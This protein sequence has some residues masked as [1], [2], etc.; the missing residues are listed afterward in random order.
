MA[1]IHVAYSV[2]QPLLPIR[3]AVIALNKRELAVKK[4]IVFVLSLAVL[5][6]TSLLSGCGGGS[7]AVVPPPPPPPPALAITTTSLATGNVG[8]LYSAGIDSNSTTPN[9]GQIWSVSSG[10]PSGLTFPPP[11]V[12]C[13]AGC[14]I[15]GT[16]TAQGTFSFTITI[17]DVNG[18]T[19]SRMFSI[20]IGPPL[21][22]SVTTPSP[23]PEGSVN[24][25]YAVA[26]QAA[27]G[28]PPFAWRLASG[29]PLPNNLALD[30]SGNISSGTLTLTTFGNF[31]FTATVTDS[32]T[33]AQ[34]A[35]ATFSLT[36]HTV[37]FG[38]YVF[39]F[40]GFDANGAV[41][42]AGSFTAD[43][44]GGITGGVEDANR[45]VSGPA[46]NVPFTGSYAMGLDNRGTL[47][48]TSSLGTSSFAFI[49]DGGQARFI[50]LDTSGTRG[51]GEMQ[52]TNGGC[53]L[54]NVAETIPYVFGM[55]GD[56]FN[57]G[58][59]ALAGSFQ[60]DGAG[61]ITA[62]ALDEND[63]GTLASNVTWTGTNATSVTSNRCTMTLT[64]AGSPTRNFASYGGNG[65]PSYL[66]E[67]DAVSS[68]V[69][70]MAGTAVAVSP[71]G[72]APAGA[73]FTNASLK[74]PIVGSLTG[75]SRVTNAPDVSLVFFSPDGNGN[76][77]MTQDENNG[78]AV[79]TDVVLTGTYNVG[80]N[81]RVTLTA[82][83]NPPVLYLANPTKAFI[84]GTDK[85][86]TFGFLEP[87]ISYGPLGTFSASIN[88]N[89]HFGTDNPASATIN[90]LSGVTPFDAT[91]TLSGTWDESTLT[92]NT[93]GQTFTGTYSVTNM[94]VNGSGTLTITP[95]A[96]QPANFVFMTLG[97][98]A[99]THSHFNGRYTVCDTWAP[100][101]ATKLIAIP[102]DATQ[103]NPAVLVLEQ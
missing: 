11:G 6:V 25:A 73:L 69:P 3:T 19:A 50:E 97:A 36:I 40:H 17:R 87:Q 51:S 81:G 28:V 74:N 83:A 77:T 92:A 53:G 65:F 70:L 37:L 55:S 32:E 1:R 67:V 24:A 72:T 80:A 26:L 103:T 16:P 95:V 93:S 79:T 68:G 45:H 4:Q 29:S 91:G 48:F 102:S 18:A 49:T 58:R 76:V 66:V 96:G 61:N 43:G 42:A 100:P 10:L 101:H 71:D 94:P 21:P 44:L 60:T 89:F 35:A 90:D 82:G 2:V 22:L 7:A 39:L 56:D 9:G 20:T 46:T 27:G 47:T 31:T 98:D 52:A 30:T 13:A 38:Q 57:K 5:S 15:S 8:T 12:T 41:V 78:G 64:M 14:G 86:A 54:G 99:C 75:Y 84:V 23:L 59:V 88:G 33:P 63:G 62:G 34:I 85:A